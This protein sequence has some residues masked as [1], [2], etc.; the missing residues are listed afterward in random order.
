MPSA[1]DIGILVTRST[2]TG[3]SRPMIAR[4]RT[5]VSRVVVLYK[6]GLATI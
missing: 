1:T 2:D 3:N 5:S 4:A 6:Q